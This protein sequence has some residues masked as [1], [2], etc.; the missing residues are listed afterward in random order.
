MSRSMR[1]SVKSL[2]I[3]LTSASSSGTERA[4]GADATTPPLAL[5]TQFVSVPFGMDSRFA[6]SLNESPWF[7]TSLTA[8]ALN[9]CV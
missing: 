2:R 6:A 9:S 5:D 4:P 7:N 1:A 8:S 3:C